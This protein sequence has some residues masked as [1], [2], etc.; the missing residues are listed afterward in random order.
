MIRISIHFSCLFIWFIYCNMYQCSTSSPFAWI[1]D[2]V[3]WNILQQTKLAT[4]NLAGSVTDFGEE[5]LNFGLHHYQVSR[6]FTTAPANNRDMV[7]SESDNLFEM[8]DFINPGGSSQTNQKVLVLFDKTRSQS[9]D[10]QV[11]WCF[12]CKRHLALLSEFV[13][14]P[15]SIIFMELQFDGMK[16]SNNKILFNWFQS[17]S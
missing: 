3:I 16:V 10:S 7:T 15:K 5:L 8:N 2:T 11:L 14:F 6:F 13:Q 17:L 12:E 4:I 1:R 9:A